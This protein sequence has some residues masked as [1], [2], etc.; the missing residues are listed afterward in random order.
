MASQRL[1]RNLRQIFYESL[2]K[3]DIQFFDNNKSGDM[4]SRLDSDTQVVQDGLT[5]NVAMFIKAICIV[6]GCIVIIATYNGWLALIVV[7]GVFPQILITR[8]S[9][10]YLRLGN[11]RYQKEK[12]EMSHIGKESISDIRTVKAFANEE[13]A[14]LRF[15]DKN[16]SLFEYGRAKGYL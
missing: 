11:V 15:A 16:Q 4:L 12:G 5:T 6:V 1:G 10:H 13:M 8:M 14:N 9:V 2:I 3:K 7:G